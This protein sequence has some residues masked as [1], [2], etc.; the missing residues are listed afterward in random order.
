M[1]T[2]KDRAI[3]VLRRRRARLRRMVRAHCVHD[4]D[5]FDMHHAAR[6][7]LQVGALI[8]RSASRASCVGE[9]SFNVNVFSS[10]VSILLLTRLK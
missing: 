7:Y 9:A 2:Q 4:H 1:V 5:L 10:L 8:R 6:V 3:G